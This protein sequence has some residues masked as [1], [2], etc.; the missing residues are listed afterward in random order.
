MYEEI[1]YNTWEKSPSNDDTLYQ[2]SFHLI[3]IFIDLIHDTIIFSACEE[4][5]QQW[6]LN[7]ALI[8]RDLDDVC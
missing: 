1:I 5:Y 6:Y 8:L 7:L 3:G 2:N 4:D